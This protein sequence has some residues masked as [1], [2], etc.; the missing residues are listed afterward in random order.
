IWL[1]GIVFFLVDQELKHIAEVSLVEGK[2]VRPF[3]HQVQLLASFHLRAVRSDAALHSRG[4]FKA[5]DAFANGWDA[6]IQY[7]LAHG[8]CKAPVA[9][10]ARRDG[11]V[12]AF[13]ANELINVCAKALRWQH[14]LALLNELFGAEQLQQ[15]I[16]ARLQTHLARALLSELQCCS[17]PALKAGR[18]PDCPS[19]A[20]GIGAAWLQA[21][22]AAAA[23]EADIASWLIPFGSVHGTKLVASSLGARGGHMADLLDRPI[24]HPCPRKLHHPG[25]NC[26]CA[27]RLKLLVPHGHSRSADLG[28]VHC[29]RL[30]N[31]KWRLTARCFRESSAELRL[32]ASLRNLADDHKGDAACKSLRPLSPDKKRPARSVI[33]RRGRMSARA[34][35]PEVIDFAFASPGSSGS[36]AKSCRT[37]RC[38]KFNEALNCEVPVLA[39]KAHGHEE[40]MFP[41][42]LS[43][44]DVT[45]KKE[46]LARRNLRA[47]TQNHRQGLS[48]T[49]ST[50]VQGVDGTRNSAADLMHAVRHAEGSADIT[51]G[52]APAN[53]I[54]FSVLS[55]VHIGDS[56]VNFNPVDASTCSPRTFNTFGFT[57]VG[58]PRG[59]FAHLLEEAS[60]A[61]G[62]VNATDSLTEDYWTNQNVYQPNGTAEPF[63]VFR[64]MKT[65]ATR[66]WVINGTSQQQV[67]LAKYFNRQLTDH[68][69]IFEAN[70]QNGEWELDTAGGIDC[71][72]EHPPSAFE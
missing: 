10:A 2:A 61:K 40:K 51:K 69:S 37:P 63:V 66:R 29:A 38:V 8:I 13:C 45:G 48:Q 9:G 14:A 62:N 49:A 18:S 28:S 68:I 17:G 33:H 58:R 30:Q 71:Q 36:S 25:E 47:M 56:E 44:V 5:L 52:D 24:P 27:E 34:G 43:S 39:V 72:H 55:K 60:Y 46:M 15:N 50:E 6:A 1:L 23:L 59:E 53:L 19:L 26:R 64:R 35:S 7:A 12:D 16:V 21:L 67:V 41:R 42:I 11:V 65:D 54:S 22:L 32:P 20:V 31:L 57:A 3:A 4:L 70:G